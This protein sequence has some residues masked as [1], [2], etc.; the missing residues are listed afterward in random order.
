MGG[1]AFVDRVTEDDKKKEGVMIQMINC[2]MGKRTAREIVHKKKT[3]DNLLNAYM[4]DIKEFKI[5]HFFLLEYANA[6]KF[7]PLK[8]VELFLNHPQSHDQQQRP[9]PGCSSGILQK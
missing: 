1:G 8:T 4:S 6:G 3:Q 2:S 7:Y 9:L 5:S